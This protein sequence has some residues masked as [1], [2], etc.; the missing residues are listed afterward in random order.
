[1]PARGQIGIFFGG[2][3]ADPFQNSVHGQTKLGQLEKQA[4]QMK[5]FEDML[6]EDGALVIKIW[7]HLTKEDQYQRLTE[8]E[9]NP[10]FHWR[11][12]PDNWKQHKLY[13]NYM[14]ASATMLEATH[15]EQNP[16]HIVDANNPRRRDLESGR[17][18]LDSMTELLENPRPVG[19]VAKNPV[20]EKRAVRHFPGTDYLGETDLESKRSK[21]DYKKQLAELQGKIGKLAWKAR[22]L[23]IPT[24]LAFEVWDASGKGGCIRR[25]LEAL[26]ARL[27]RTVSVAAPTQEEIAQHYLWRFW[28]QLP[29]PGMCAVF[30]R[31][32]YGRVLVERVE[33]FARQEEW[34]RAY[35]EINDFEKQLTDH[36]S[37]LCK[38]WL[39][40]SPQ[41]QL[42]RFEA[43]E[44]IPFKRHKIT[45]DDWRNRDK[46]NLYEAAVNDMIDACSAEDA[47]WTIVPANDKRYARIMVLKTF[48]KALNAAVEKKQEKKD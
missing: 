28:R 39:H 7:Q 16:W 29:R 2:W 12:L 27:Y 41:E 43:R 30:D 31:S 1:M 38:F 42:Q 44:Q 48:Y 17:I 40:I 14:K 24:V 45:P 32:W 5:R 18:I 9:Q 4:Q 20:K 8:L 21:G 25:L 15:T 13:E 10:R 47:P 46:W 22:D 33:G 26:D 34:Q 6:H 3:Y 36:G 37:I 19:G 11:V 23:K 35:D